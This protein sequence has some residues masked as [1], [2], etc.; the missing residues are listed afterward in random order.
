MSVNTNNADQT[1]CAMLV[2][3]MSA[4][5]NTETTDGLPRTPEVNIYIATCDQT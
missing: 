3:T 2:L 1:A 4:Q 5:W